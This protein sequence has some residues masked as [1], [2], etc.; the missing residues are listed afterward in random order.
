[1][2]PKYVSDKNDIKKIQKKIFVGL[3]LDLLMVEDLMNGIIERTMIDAIIARTP[4]NLDGM[5]RR[6]AYANKKY[7]SGTIWLGVL[8]GLATTKLSASPKMKG[9]NKTKKNKITNTNM[10]PAMSLIVK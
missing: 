6:M 9:K 1:M 7:H 8:I 5:E 10:K 2:E 4:P 3:N